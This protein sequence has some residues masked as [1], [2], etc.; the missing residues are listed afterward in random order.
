MLDRFL[1]RTLHHVMGPL[2][3]LRGTCEIVSDGLQHC[4]I[5]GNK[6]EKNCELLDR[7]AETVTTTTRMVADISDLA[8]FDE[9]VTLR[10]KCNLVDLR[11]LGLEA[12]EKI[13]FNDL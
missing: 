13:P 1:S 2:H 7:A 9:G 5:N 8:R 11:D 12:M 3:T 10:T 6:R 4:N